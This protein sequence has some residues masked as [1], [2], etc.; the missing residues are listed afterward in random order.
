[1]NSDILVTDFKDVTAKHQL[2]TVASSQSV[3]ITLPQLLLERLVF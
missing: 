2:N 1:M 3:N